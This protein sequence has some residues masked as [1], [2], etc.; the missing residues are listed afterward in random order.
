MVCFCFAANFIIVL[1]ALQSLH[2]RFCEYNALFGRLLFQ[3][4]QAL[5]DTG[6]R[7]PAR[8]P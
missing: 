2:L 7:Y 3:S 5:F 1:F 4:A 8:S 6:K